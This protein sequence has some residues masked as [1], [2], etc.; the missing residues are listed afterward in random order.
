[1]GCSQPNTECSKQT[2]TPI[3]AGNRTP[4]MGAL[5]LRTPH[6]PDQNFLGTTLWSKLRLLDSSF[7][8]LCGSSQIL[9]SPQVFLPKNLRMS[10]LILEDLSML[11]ALDFVCS[12]CSISIYYYYYYFNV[13]LFLRE[14]ETTE[15]E[16][17]R[18]RE[19]GRHRIR[20]RL[21][22]LSCQHRAQ[23]RA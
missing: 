23:C 3:P 22:A 8:V 2:M 4:L 15:C 6:W 9:F 20:R 17:G 18:G 7:S 12:K 11:I 16:L 5:G 1:M 21:Q 10:S 19:R 14:G 13:Y